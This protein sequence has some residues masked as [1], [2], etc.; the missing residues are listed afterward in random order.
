VARMYLE[1]EHFIIRLATSPARGVARLWVDDPELEGD[2]K[3]QVLIVPASTTVE[4]RLWE[5]ESDE[6]PILLFAMGEIPDNLPG[7][8]RAISLNE[9]V[10]W[11]ISNGVGTRRVQVDVPALDPTVIES[12]RGLDA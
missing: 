8:I 9:L 2:P 1:Q 7:R 11:M 5:T 4:R 12:I 10:Q 6:S 3:T